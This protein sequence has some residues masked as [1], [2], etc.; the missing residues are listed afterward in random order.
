[1][2]IVR[3]VNIVKK[4]GV[5]IGSETLWMDITG[6]ITFHIGESILKP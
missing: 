3:N 4:G 2:N 5:E 1:M 6:A